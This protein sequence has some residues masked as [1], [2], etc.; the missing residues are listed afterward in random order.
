MAQ[1]KPVNEILTTS[2]APDGYTAFPIA[3]ARDGWPFD[4]TTV[5]HIKPDKPGEPFAEDS[6]SN[7]LPSLHDRVKIM[8]I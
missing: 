8:T 6:I 2:A 3:L 5:L 1:N 4:P 7:V